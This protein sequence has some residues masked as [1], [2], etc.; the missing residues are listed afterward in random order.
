MVLAD[1]DWPRFGWCADMRAP[2]ADARHRR[3]PVALATIVHLEGSAPRPIG[4]QMLFEGQRAAG[5]FT[6]G[7]LEADIAAHARE[8][9]GNGEAKLLVYGRGSPWI[10]IRLTCGGRM[11]ILVER[12]DP[13]DT[14]VEALLEAAQ[15]RR[16]VTWISNGTTRAVRPGFTA[17]HWDGRAREVLLPVEPVRRLLVAGQDP[18]ALAIAELGRQA[19]W[20]AILLRPDAVATDGVASVIP[21]LPACVAAIE[22]A[23][24][25]TA[26]AV[27]THDADIDHDLI[28]AALRSSSR[29]VGALGARSRLAGRRARLRA[30]GLDPAPLHAPMGIGHT[31][32]A[33]WEIAVS[34]LAEIMTVFQRYGLQA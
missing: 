14:G 11:E 2:L 32:K 31:G 20:D 19:G 29:Y 8:V 24:P 5:Y 1:A 3:V 22:A 21:G 34:V 16:P 30:E 15:E 9:V 6:G 26:I 13:N 25:W 7:C 33:P 18:T 17:A 23:D 4:T 27:A 10:D 12:I 28:A